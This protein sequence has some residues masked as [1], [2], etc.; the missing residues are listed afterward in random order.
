MRPNPHPPVPSPFRGFYRPILIGGSLLMLLAI[1]AIWPVTLAVAA[2]V[3]F[4]L[5]AITPLIHADS[6]YDSGHKEVDR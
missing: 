4:M 1:F 5:M 6:F 3:I 2:F